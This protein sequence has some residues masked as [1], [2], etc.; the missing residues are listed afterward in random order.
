MTIRLGV[1]LSRVRVEE[2]WIL[3]ALDKRGVVYDRID[4]RLAAFDFAAP[5]SWALQRGAGAQ[6]VVL[7]RAV[8]HP[9]AQRLGHPHRQHGA[10]G[11]GVRR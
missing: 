2:K 1:L 3:E 6:P 7:A 11:G 8:C 10:G 9:G 4:D 5:G